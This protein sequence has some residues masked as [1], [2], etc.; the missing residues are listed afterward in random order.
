MNDPEILDAW[1][2][3]ETC[4]TDHDGWPP[5]TFGAAHACTVA[6]LDALLEPTWWGRWARTY[7]VWSG[8]WRRTRRRWVHRWR[9]TRRWWVHRV[10]RR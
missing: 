5:G 4:G 10:T 8:R 1:P 3:C 2:L 6:R 7:A 9:R